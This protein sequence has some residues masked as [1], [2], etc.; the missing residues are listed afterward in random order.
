MPCTGQC[1][2][3][4]TL[5]SVPPIRTAELQLRE[6]QEYAERQGWQIADIYQDVISGAK[7]SRP[8]LNRL[9]ADA[10]A[11]NS[12]ACWSG[13]WTALAGPSWTA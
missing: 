9:M 2:R 10:L 5:A 12:I 4:S 1:A 6:V 11:T 3:P 8:G 7:A 13:S